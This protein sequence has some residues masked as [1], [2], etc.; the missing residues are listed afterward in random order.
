MLIKFEGS[1]YE[2]D[3][4]EMSSQEAKIIKRETGFSLMKLQEGLLELDPDAI[5]AIYW[6]MHKQNGTAIDMRRA[7]F[8]VIQFGKAVIDAFADDIGDEEEAEEEAPKD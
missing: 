6:L 8:K 7:D 1:E 5:T 2:F 3:L 4:E